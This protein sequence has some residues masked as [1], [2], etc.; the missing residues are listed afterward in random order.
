MSQNARRALPR[1]LGTPTDTPP[2]TLLMSSKGFNPSPKRAVRDPKT[3]RGTGGPG[4]GSEAHAL[5]HRQ[6][7]VVE[8]CNT[9]LCRSCP[10]E[11]LV[12]GQRL[13]EGEGQA[14]GPRR[15]PHPEDERHGAG[16]P[17]LMSCDILL[18]LTSS[19]AHVPLEP[20]TFIFRGL[21][22]KRNHEGK[23]AHSPAFTLDSIV[24][25]TREKLSVS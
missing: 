17:V 9:V 6:P 14:G 16:D 23:R 22:M 11:E 13:E 1:H 20:H 12:R 15:R 5:M 19:P 21:G 4:S 24:T 2:S 25:A 7:C 18:S 3:G 8:L 10:G